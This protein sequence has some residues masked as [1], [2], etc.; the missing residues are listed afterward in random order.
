[1]RL[2]PSHQKSRYDEQ[3]NTDGQCNSDGKKFHRAIR[4]FAFFNQREQAGRHAQYDHQ[5]H[6]GYDYFYHGTA[7]VSELKPAILTETVHRLP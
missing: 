6:D 4:R 5:K 1:M 3:E 7:R 2:N